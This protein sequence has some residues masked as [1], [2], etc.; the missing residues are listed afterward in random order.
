MPSMATRSAHLDELL[1]REV[2]RAGVARAATLG[3][4]VW[5]DGLWLEAYGAAGSVGGA[6][7]AVDTP[8]DLA[9]VTKPVTAV[10]CARLVERGLLAWDWPVAELLP[11]LAHTA[12]GQRTVGEHLS[13]R[14]GLRAHVELFAPLR[15]QRPVDPGQLLARAAQSVRAR[16]EAPADASTDAALY[17]DLGY[18][19][20]G[21]GLERLT[22]TPL[23]ELVAGEILSGAAV[24]TEDRQRW[25]LGSSR[26]W[27]TLRP[28]FV[29]E[30]APTE[31][32]PWRGG[33][34]RGVVH[35]DNA[36]ALGGFR[37]CGHA[38]LFGS[39][40][41]VVDLGKRLVESLESL[42]PSPLLSRSTLEELVRARPGG[43]L[44]MGFDGK[45]GPGSL[46]GQLT[47][48]RTFG[49]LGY[50]GTSLWCDPD[51][52]LVTVLLTNRVHPSAANVRIRQ[53]RPRIQDQLFQLTWNGRWDL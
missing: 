30:V 53:A 13:H 31:H 27:R 10:T 1:D 38:G 36:W 26:Q 47:G 50:T 46:A 18:V 28:K 45:A 3:V 41:A 11:E 34:L 9:S 39:A 48:P 42:A 32:V 19:L 21:A 40:P 8:F 2:L 43:S 15:A 37:S 4:A 12:G 29:E 5:R 6:P 44:R 20:V 17:S 16:D 7:T 22:G 35:D 49:H 23:D 33:V 25:V 24:G 51:V 14:A 52:R